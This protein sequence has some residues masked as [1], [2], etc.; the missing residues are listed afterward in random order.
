MLSVSIVSMSASTAV[1]ISVRKVELSN[2]SVWTFS[3]TIPFIYFTSGRPKSEGGKT[4][5]QAF[6]SGSSGPEL[7]YNPAL[8]R[9]TVRNA[10][11]ASSE[12]RKDFRTQLLLSISNRLPSIVVTTPAATDA[13]SAAVQCHTFDHL[14]TVWK[15]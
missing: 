9:S 3:P 13:K 4:I 11:D 1:S 5:L 6:H 7:V 12:I 10:S 2:P 15:V 14:L 8:F